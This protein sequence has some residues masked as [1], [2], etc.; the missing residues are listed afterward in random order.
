[1]RLPESPGRENTRGTRDDREPVL[2]HLSSHSPHPCP[3]YERA[4]RWLDVVVALASILV[5]APVLALMAVLIKLTSRGPVFYRGTV[6]GRYGRPF[7]YYKFRTMRTDLGDTAHRDFIREYVQGSSSTDSGVF[8]LVDDPR[9]TMV[10]RWMRWTS[11][12]EMAQMINVLRGD[13][14]I[15]GPRPPV[16]YEYEHY[17][18]YHQQRLAVLPGITGLAQVQARSRAS[19]EEMVAIDLEYIRRR[20]LRLDLAIMAETVWVMLT[21]RGAH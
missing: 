6:I 15:V 5:L 13:M 8:K 16:P 12:D 11:L 19:F 9:I 3:R 7:T 14:S 20:S 4:K 18:S 10:G 17:T 1:M 21:G 2:S